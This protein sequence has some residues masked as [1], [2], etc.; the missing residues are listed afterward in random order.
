MQL[1][2]VIAVVS[3]ALAVLLTRR[4]SSPSQ[5]TEPRGTILTIGVQIICGNCSGDDPRPKKTYLERFGT[6][7]ECGG[8]SYILA[9]NCA[10][11][12]DRGL[13]GTPDCELRIAD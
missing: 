9:S 7:A 6:C 3:F 4:E 2:I 1:I 10:G 11:M 5:L 13:K 12:A 8:R